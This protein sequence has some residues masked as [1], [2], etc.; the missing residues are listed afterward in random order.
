MYTSGTTGNPKGVVISHG[1]V[2][3]L[4]AAGEQVFAGM[5]E[6]GDTVLAYLPLAHIMEIAS[7]IEVVSMCVFMHNLRIATAGRS[8]FSFAPMNHLCMC[9]KNSNQPLK[10]K[11]N[12]QKVK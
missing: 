2:A 8:C 1:N 12:H 6:A 11:I 9:C 3:A 5:V 4:I 7:R 10:R